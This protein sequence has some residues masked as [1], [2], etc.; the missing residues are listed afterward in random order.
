MPLIVCG[1]DAGGT[2]PIVDSLFGAFCHRDPSRSLP[3][4]AGTVLLCARCTGLYAGALAGGLSLWVRRRPGFPGSSKAAWWALLLAIFATPLQAVGE[5]AGAW[6]G[7]PALRMALGLLTGT[8]LG[9]ILLRPAGAVRA[10]PPGFAGFALPLLLDGAFLLLFLVAPRWG[11]TGTLIGSAALIGGI[12]T[13]LG[14][15]AATLVV[16]ALK[17]FAGRPLEELRHG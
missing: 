17:P 8:A 5:A 6:E 15:L 7:S 10:G 1:S 13:L 3:F 2:W 4:A 9:A 16:A 12:M 14:G 11:S